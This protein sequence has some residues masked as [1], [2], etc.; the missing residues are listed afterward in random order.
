MHV[1]NA[2]LSACTA[3]PNAS[4][5]KISRP[6]QGVSHL[7]RIAVTCACW[8][9]NWCRAEALLPVRPVLYAHRYAMPARVNVKNTNTWIIASNAPKFAEIAPKNAGRWAMLKYKKTGDK[10]G[11]WALWHIL[12]PIFNI[13]FDEIYS[14]RSDINFR[15]GSI[16]QNTARKRPDPS[17]LPMNGAY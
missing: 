15:Q 8:L 10:T 16:F 7:T 13:F 2:P 14:P 1:I 12:R 9:L 4:M 5:K 17:F 6:W 11:A 3:P